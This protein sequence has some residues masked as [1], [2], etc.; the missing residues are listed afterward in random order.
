MK[1]RLMI[2]RALW[3]QPPVLFLNEPTRGLDPI[4][5]GG[6]RR[7]IEQLGRQGTAILLTTHLLEEADQLC[8]RLSF[9]VNGRLVAGGTP[10][11]LG[12]SHGQRALLVTLADPSQPGQMMEV[13]LRMDDPDDQ[14]RLTGWQAEG[15]VLSVHSQE[16]TLEEVFLNVAGIRPA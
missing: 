9:I 1:Q 16:A 7:T 8:Q 14:A 6:V 5:A 12:L 3:H 11:Q 4:A 15:N 13:R 2:A 10:P